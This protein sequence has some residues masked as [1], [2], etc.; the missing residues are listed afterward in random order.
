M[1]WTVITLIPLLSFISFVAY[2]IMTSIEE[3]RPFDVLQQRLFSGEITDNEYSCLYEDLKR[4]YMAVAE[5]GITF[6]Q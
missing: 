6:I 1:F 3:D 4:S 2:I 5:R